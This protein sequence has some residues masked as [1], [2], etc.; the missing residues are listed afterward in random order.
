VIVLSAMPAAA[1]V[2]Q[3]EYYH[4]EAGR[5]TRIE[6]ASTAER[7]GFELQLAPVRIERLEGGLYRGAL[8][9]KL[10]YGILPR[11]E[12]EVR[13]PLVVRQKGV[14]PRTG[15]SGVGLGGS[16]AFNTES[17][18]VPALGLSGAVVLPVGNAAASTA[19]FSLRGIATRTFGFGRVHVNVARGLYATAAP[20]TPDTAGCGAASC[21]PVPYVPDPPCFAVSGTRP[22]GLPALSLSCAGRQLAVPVAR[23]AAGRA[24]A[25]LPTDRSTFWFAGVAADR[26]IPLRSL[27]VSGA[28]FAE[29][30]GGSERPVEATAEVGTRWQRSP[31]IVL[32]LGFGH[33]FAGERRSWYTTFGMTCSFAVPLLIRLSAR[34]GKS[35]APGSAAR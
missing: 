21:E 16:L 35:P 28:L 26:A 14:T 10:S 24:A 22:A 11:A 13:T 3:T 2:G 25:A 4:A 1:A 33:R 9:P 34:A 17:Q 19:A 29:Q 6:D 18:H 23:R 31:R 20:T 8:E 27:L 15:L 30:Y 5:P 32:D 12:L 7:Y